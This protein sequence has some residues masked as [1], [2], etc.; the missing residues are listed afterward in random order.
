MP[1]KGAEV[2]PPLPSARLPA[3][4]SLSPGVERRLIGIAGSKARARENWP[5]GFDQAFAARDEL[6]GEVTRFS[7]AEKNM[8]RHPIFLLTGMLFPCN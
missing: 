8:A 5:G 1:G 2:K 3:S 6:S 7:L 4:P